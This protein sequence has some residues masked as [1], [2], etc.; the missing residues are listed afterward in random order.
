MPI[1]EA[2]YKIIYEK[3]RPDE[4]MRELLSRPVKEETL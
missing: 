4:V 1:S 2:V 3:R